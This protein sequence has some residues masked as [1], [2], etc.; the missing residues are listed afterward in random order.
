MKRKWKIKLGTGM[1][2]ENTMTL[3][4]TSIEKRPTIWIRNHCIILVALEYKIDQKGSCEDWKEVFTVNEGILDEV[5]EDKPQVY[6]I[7]IK[8]NPYYGDE[9]A[10][11]TPE[12]LGRF[13]QII[14]RLGF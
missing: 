1:V 8:I 12:K 4:I 5:E 14:K 13:S 10:L 9:I 7:K 11:S 6:L 2:E 3:I